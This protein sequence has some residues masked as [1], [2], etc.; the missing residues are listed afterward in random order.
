MYRID[1]GTAAAALPAPTADGPN[2]DKFFTSGDAGT[3]VPPTLVDAEW[4]NMVQEE[5]AAVVAGASIPLN[6]GG[7][8]QLLTAIQALI[9]AGLP[10][11]AND[12]IFIE[13]ATFE[14]SVVD[15]NIVRWDSGSNHFAKAIADGTANG[16]AV[17][18]A[19]V[20]NSEV[21]LFGDLPAGLVSGLTPGS[22]L[23]LSNTVAGAFT[24]TAPAQAIKVGFTKSATDMFVDV[25]QEPVATDQ[26]LIVVD[27]KTSGTNG[28][29]ISTG[30]W[31]T[32]DLNT[33]DVN[34]ITG[35]SLA[36][37][38]V[39]LPAGTYR[40]WFITSAVDSNQNQSRMYDIT[41]SSTLVLGLTA[42]DNA[43]QRNGSNSTGVG[44]FTLAATTAIELQHRFN[45]SN[46][47]SWHLGRSASFG[48]ERYVFV[49]IEKIS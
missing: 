39:T 40:A 36:A 46:G 35:A 11:V 20:T 13:A 42:A 45:Y 47:Y 28:G 4:L 9:I 34:T 31:R 37:N 7:R 15:G 8:T 17:G 49:E 27:E 23:Y 14:G 48:P 41:N 6:K 3:G 1:N 25:D 32:R 43:G 22:A 19:N 44:T 5:L 33:V 21:T 18:I 30:A 26:R 10:S 29:S 2:P 12:R 24:T 38:Q 16:H